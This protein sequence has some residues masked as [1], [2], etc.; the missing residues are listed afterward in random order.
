MVFGLR[1]DGQVGQAVES[2][3]KAL[4][5]DRCYCLTGCY[6]RDKHEQNK[7]CRVMDYGLLHVLFTPPGFFLEAEDKE[8]EYTEDD[9]VLADDDNVRR[10][11]LLQLVVVVVSIEHKKLLTGCD[12]SVHR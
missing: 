7:V 11:G 9:E 10:W 5:V 12:S 8:S 2:L 1:E 4:A 6:N 3:D